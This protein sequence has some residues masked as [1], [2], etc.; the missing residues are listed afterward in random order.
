VAGEGPAKE[1]RWK[2]LEIVHR[3]FGE[4][5]FVKIGYVRT[6]NFESITN[7][8]VQRNKILIEEFQYLRR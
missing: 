7:D 6:C 3:S 1:S 5:F 8:G 2:Q 4:I